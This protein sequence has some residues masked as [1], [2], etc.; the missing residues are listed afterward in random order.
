VKKKGSKPGRIVLKGALTLRTIDETQVA[1]RDGLAR[2][3]Q[4]EIDCADATEVDLAAIQ[5]LLAA[6]K[7]AL[8][9]KKTFALTAP[10]SG[11]LREALLRG[12][13]LSDATDSTAPADSFWLKGTGA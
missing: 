11:P 13:F 2:H 3:A 6:R 7:S 4:I 12:G 1:L 10:A 8:D 9:A 5:L